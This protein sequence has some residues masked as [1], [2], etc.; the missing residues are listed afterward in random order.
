MS[1]EEFINL[2][3]IYNDLLTINQKN[4]FKSYYFEDLSL[5]EIAENYNVSKTLIG[6]TLKQVENKLIDLENSL[7]INNILNKLET[8]KDR[9]ND[10]DVIT[11]I[12]SILNIYDVK[13]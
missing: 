12:D 1:R 9:T 11:E 10:K 6:K 13:E 4:Y 3:I 8:I 7:K 2:Y 5:S